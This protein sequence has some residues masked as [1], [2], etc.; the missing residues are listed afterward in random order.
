MKQVFIP[1][2]QIQK[3]LYV[4][5]SEMYGKEAPLYKL[6]LAVNR[7]VNELESKEHPELGVT[8]EMLNQISSE[9]HGAIRVA[10]PVEFA[11][12]SRFFRVMD[13]YPHNA[14]MMTN[15]G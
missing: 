1:Q 12:M 7:H 4:A 10:T 13:M 2:E 5:L 3:E 9:R 15:A 6:L 11:S 14:Y 8:V